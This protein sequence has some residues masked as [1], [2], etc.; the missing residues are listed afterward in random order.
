MG[1]ESKEWWI[2][3]NEGT[4]ALITRMQQAESKNHAETQE[5]AR[6]PVETGP[7]RQRFCKD[8]LPLTARAYL[9]AQSALLTEGCTITFLSVFCLHDVI[10]F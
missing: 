7:T 8:P 5:T 10:Q 1:E 3:V 4:R 6:T 2:V 9:H